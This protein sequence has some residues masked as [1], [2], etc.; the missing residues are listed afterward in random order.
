M[1]NSFTKHI[2]SLIFFSLI[3]IL[4]FLNFN[5]YEYGFAFVYIGFIIF[6][7]LNTPSIVLLISA[8]IQGLFI[9]LFY[10]TIGVNAFILV[11]LAYLK[12]TLSKL[13]IPKMIDDIN[14]LKS[15]NQ[16]GIE[17]AILV[18][19]ILTFIH[20]LFLFFIINGDSSFI[21]DNI[22]KTV[23][24]AIITTSLLFSFKKMFFNSL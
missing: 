9:D 21:F 7:P 23:I 8:F 6:L 12:P 13:F 10:N 20:H 2:F 19:F 14:D 4:F 15:I 5:I 11:L 17:R 3:Q 1:S 24:S 22:I 16:L 18:V